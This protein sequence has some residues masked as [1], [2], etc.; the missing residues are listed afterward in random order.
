MITKI[1][2]SKIAIETPREDSETWVHI[3]VQQVLKKDDGTVINIIPRFDYISF[4]IKDV[5]LNQ[6]AFSDPVTQ[7]AMNMSGYTVGSAIAAIVISTLEKK[8]GGTVTPQGDL[9]V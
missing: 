4:P 7:A 6:F 1:R 9:I 3:T 8:Y 2:A 5:G